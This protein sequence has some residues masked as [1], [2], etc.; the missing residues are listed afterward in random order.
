MATAAFAFAMAFLSY[1][2][3]NSRS[4]RLSVDNHFQTI[5]IGAGP[6]GLIAGKHLKDGL[7]LD[8]KEEIGTPVHCGEGISKKALEAEGIPADSFFI[9]CA[10][11]Q[12]ER[13]MP[14]GASMGQYHQEPIGYI[15]NRTRFEQYLASQVKC[16][17][18]L[19]SKVI[20]LNFI[21]NKW[22]VTTE[23]NQVFTA[24]YIIAADGFNSLARKKFFPESQEQ[25]KFIPAISYFIKTARP[26][27]TKKVKIFLDSQK[28]PQGYG[29]IFP[30]SLHTANIGIGGKGNLL[31][32]FS[33]FV[34]EKIQN[35]LGAFALLENKS[36]TVTIK[37]NG[38]VVFAKNNILLT[39]DAAGFA[40]PIFKAGITQ[41]MRSGRLAAQCILQN[42]VAQYDE[43]IK[44]MPFNDSSLIKASDI[45]YSFDN[46]TLN[47]MAEVFNHNNG[48]SG[49][50]IISHTA[51]ALIRPQFLF[52]LPK[53]F[54]FLHTWKTHQDQ[55]W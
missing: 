45:L 18:K 52:K 49:F 3:K 27:D 7:I 36:G 51:K 15:I 21:N 30:K 38:D 6:A 11:H 47:D 28:Y 26:L 2:A 19:N 39:G 13:I 43:K 40:D 8:Q 12:I 41:A 48:L 23:N 24:E 53:M 44:A 1:Q 32:S 22:H 14:N 37:E 34:K 46:S 20:D 29:W 4:S 25:I 10:V 33:Q 55:L 35:E 17:I 31:P 54:S 50:G 9:D 5:I 42:Q 16:P